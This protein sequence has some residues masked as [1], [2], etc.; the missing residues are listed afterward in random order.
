MA[1]K[2]SMSMSTFNATPCNVRRRPRSLRL[3]S[4]AHGRDLGG[5]AVD[6]GPHARIAVQPVDP[7]K[8]A[9]GVKVT[10]GR[11]DGVL[12]SS[13]VYLAGRGVVGDGDDRPG[14]DLTGCVIRDVPAAVGVDH[15]GLER[16]RGHKEMFVQCS[17][18]S[19]VRRRVFEHQM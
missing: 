11:D 1:L 7:S 16:L 12:E 19:R 2:P 6:V 13:D 4:N 5:N 3:G 9:L 8:S 14:H 10:N 18:T 15:H 17:N